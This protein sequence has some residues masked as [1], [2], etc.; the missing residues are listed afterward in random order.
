[1]VWAGGAV[2]QPTITRRIRL[3]AD[4]TAHHLSVMIAPFLDQFI[5]EGV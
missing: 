4:H 5:D 3:D 1:M 2:E